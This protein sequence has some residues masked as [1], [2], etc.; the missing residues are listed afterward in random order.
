MENQY[1]WEQ[2]EERAKRKEQQIQ[3]LHY[4]KERQ[5][6]KT[7]IFNQAQEWARIQLE[8]KLSD[9]EIENFIKKWLK[10]LYHE[11]KLWDIEFDNLYFQN[12]QD[13]KR[14]QLKDKNNNNEK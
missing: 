9:E 13:K 4:S 10:K 1:N 8:F 11:Y 7:S 2:I 14:S 6:I 5:V 12:I 3:R